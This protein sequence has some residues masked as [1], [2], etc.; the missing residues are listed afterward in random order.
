M[1]AS[2]N[3]SGAAVEKKWPLYHPFGRRRGIIL[4]GNSASHQDSFTAEWLSKSEQTPFGTMI[5]GGGGL[6]LWVLGSANSHKGKPCMEF[7]DC[8]IEMLTLSY[9]ELPTV[10]KIK[11]LNRGE[12]LAINMV[13]RMD[14]SI[15][16]KCKMQGKWK[17]RGWERNMLF[18]SSSLGRLEWYLLEKQS[19]HLPQIHKRMWQDEKCMYITHR[20]LKPSIQFRPTMPCQKWAT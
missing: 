20:W 19:F 12:T 2:A 5:S 17:N 13:M 16:L 14:V 9:R 18:W 10:S 1:K 4:D 3:C 11:Q 6:H 15:K 7:C 8:R